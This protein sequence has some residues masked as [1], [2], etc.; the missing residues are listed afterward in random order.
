MPFCAPRV[1]LLA[2]ALAL[3]A[4]AADIRERIRLATPQG[5]AVSPSQA[6]D[7]TL[8]LTE[9][10]NR[11][12]QNWLRT[13]GAIDPAG[14]TVMAR[15]G[16]AEAASLAVGQRARV[17]PVESRSSMYQ[18]RISRIVPQTGGVLVEATLAAKSHELNAPYVLEITVDYGEFLSV[19]NEAIIEEGDRQVVYVQGKGGSYQARDVTTRLQGERY[20]Q[21]LEGVEAGEMVVTTG[22]FFIDAEYRMKGGD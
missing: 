13:A 20:T 17:F 3:A 15:V 14:R 4:D 16:N 5:T 18:A 9:V 22:S 1:F 8:T 19:P 21:V 7:L 11:P 10:Q 6:G 12:I 2:A